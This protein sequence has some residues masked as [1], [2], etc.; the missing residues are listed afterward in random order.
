MHPVTPDDSQRDAVVEVAERMA[1]SLTTSVPAL[2]F[3]IRE[4]RLL[5]RDLRYG[6]IPNKV[7]PGAVTQPQSSR[8]RR[9]VAAVPI[10]SE[11]VLAAIA[12]P[13]LSLGL[14]LFA[15]L[16]TI[17]LLASH[18]YIRMVASVFAA[19]VFAILCKTEKAIFA[20]FARQSDATKP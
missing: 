4:A 2:L 3:S 20:R 10:D 9:L 18:M 7:T 5:W 14:S 13:R 15:L 1:C 17:Y 12:S 6:A 8:L 11:A 16:L 19:L